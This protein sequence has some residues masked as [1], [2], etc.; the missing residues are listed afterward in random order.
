MHKHFL[1]KCSN[2][3]ITFC[4]LFVKIVAA[5]FM[6][7]LCLKLFSI[8]SFSIPQSHLEC[9]NQV[10]L[11]SKNNVANSCKKYYK[12]QTYIF[13]LLFKPYYHVSSPICRNIMVAVF[14]TIT[15]CI[16]INDIQ[17]VSIIRMCKQ[18]KMMLVTFAKNI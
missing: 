5:V 13:G 4:I 18:V 9:L 16:F 12:I 17:N 15:Q 14:N 3:S 6:C 2:Y 10:A 1:A 11:A 7:L 8:Q